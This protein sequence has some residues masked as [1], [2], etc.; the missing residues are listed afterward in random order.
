VGRGRNNYPP[1][2]RE[3][4]VRMVTEGAAGVSVGLAGDARGGEPAYPRSGGRPRHGLQ[5]CTVWRR[6]L[7]VAAA[8]PQG[9]SESFDRPAI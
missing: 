9:M 3:R 5:R 4:G 2:L 7:G 6:C 8:G 1:E